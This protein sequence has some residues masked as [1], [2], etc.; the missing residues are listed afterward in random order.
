MVLKKLFKRKREYK[1]LIVYIEMHEAVAYYA[2]KRGI[3]IFRA[4]GKLLEI[5][6]GKEFDVKK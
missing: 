3:T 4:T 1:H 5:A 2:R 6:L